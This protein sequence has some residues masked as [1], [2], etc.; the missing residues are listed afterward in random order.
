MPCSA[1]SPWL[2]VPLGLRLRK[3]E[4]WYRELMYK[5]LQ[6]GPELLERRWKEFHT[7]RLDPPGQA[8]IERIRSTGAKLRAK[9]H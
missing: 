3:D 4:V 8:V 9:D 5:H 1:Y 7:P 2:P 6:R